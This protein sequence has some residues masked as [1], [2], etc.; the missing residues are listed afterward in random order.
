MIKNSPYNTLGKA[1]PQTVT[2][3]A[4]IVQKDIETFRTDQNVGLVQQV[5]D[6]APRWLIKKL[7]LTYLTLG[8]S[9]IGREVGLQADEVRAVVLNMVSPLLH[10]SWVSEA[11]GENRSRR[12]TSMRAY[13]P[14]GTLPSETR[15]PNLRRRTSTQRWPRR[16]HRVSFCST[17]RGRSTPAR[18]ICRRCVLCCCSRM[19]SI[20]FTVTCRRSSTRTTRG[21]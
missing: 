5:I 2:I 10:F 13:R 12:A 1:Y 20:D 18:S 15:R 3:L 9:D 7:T 4:A 17:S 11:D 19:S 16:R 8:L 6:R 14:M 21:A